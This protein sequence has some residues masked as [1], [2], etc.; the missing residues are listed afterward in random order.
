MAAT[1][2]VRLLVRTFA[3]SLWL[4]R[5]AMLALPRPRRIMCFEYW[6]LL[7]ESPQYQMRQQAQ[8]QAGQQAQEV[9]KQISAQCWILVQPALH[10]PHGKYSIFSG[11]QKI[12]LQAS[13]LVV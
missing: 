5:F 11:D 13:G 4:A 3:I 10:F 9:F 2:Q 8:Q 12:H 1:T 7:R 6:S